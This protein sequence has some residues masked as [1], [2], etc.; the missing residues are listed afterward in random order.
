[1]IFLQ[2]LEILRS[3]S[4]TECQR[5]KGSIE[6]ELGLSTEGEQP[7]PLLDVS[8]YSASLP[9]FDKYY[10]KTRVTHEILQI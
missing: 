1:M 6:G 3:P 4:G 5:E 9:D 7:L 2:Q 8:I 10:P